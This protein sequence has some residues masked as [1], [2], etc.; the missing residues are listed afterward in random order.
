MDDDEKAMSGMRMSRKPR[1]IKHEETK[2]RYN[3]FIKITS[4]ES[5]I[6]F[7]MTSPSLH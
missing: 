6:D 1:V 7:V 3:V 4:C 5:Q 2:T